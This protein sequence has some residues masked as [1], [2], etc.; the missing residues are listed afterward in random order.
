[1]SASDRQAMIQ[2]MVDKQAAGLKANPHDREGWE[3]LMRARMVLGQANL[4]AQA[5]R[6]AS[7]AFAGSPADQA[8]LRQTA[9]SL[10]IPGI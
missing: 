5:Y 3:R 9:A 6:D 2:G 8:A 4:A 1:M 7:K 10:A